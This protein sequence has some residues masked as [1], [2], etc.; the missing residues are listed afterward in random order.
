[1]QKPYTFRPLNRKYVNTFQKIVN[2]F[3]FNWTVQ[4][5]A[6]T[7]LIDPYFPDNPTYLIRFTCFF[8]M[9]MW[10]TPEMWLY[11]GIISDITFGYFSDVSIIIIFKIALN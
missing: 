6:K 7:N 11:T 2:S 10:C 4:K 8:A 1:M 3:F 9:Y 5:K